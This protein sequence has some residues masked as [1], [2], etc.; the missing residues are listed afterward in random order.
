MQ[1]RNFG[2]YFDPES[3]IELPGSYNS[4]WITLKS[5]NGFVEGKL[6]YPKHRGRDLII[7]EPGFP[8]DGSTRLEK[9]WLD[10]I[11]EKGF[12][13]FTA[14][15]SGTIING[16]Y[17]DNYLNCPQKQE[18]AKNHNQRLLGKKDSYTIADWLIEPLVALEALES[19]FSAIYLIGHSFGGLAI[20]YSLIELAKKRPDKA[21]KVQRLISLAGSTGKVKDQNDP[22]LKQWADYLPRDSTKERIDI[23]DPNETLKILKNA[24]K[25][26][27]KEANLIPESTEAICVMVEND[28]LV[29]IHEAKDIIKTL[30]RGYLVIDK[31]EKADEKTD[32]LAHDMDNMPPEK[33]L[34]FV[35]I[36][37]KPTLKT[38]TL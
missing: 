38:S 5:K 26:I 6:H 27:H 24:Y 17:A 7:F 34:D 22:I 9:L 21:S 23:G 35:N 14:R 28:E 19:M 20:Y 30:G 25:K 37:W 15:H 16:K 31:K 3:V 13:V 18:W 32:R 10:K 8:G 29:P 11:L 33:I 2:S 4:K 36:D 12:T 1:T